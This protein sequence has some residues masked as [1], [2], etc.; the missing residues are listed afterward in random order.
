LLIHYFQYPQCTI[1]NTLIGNL[2]TVFC[3]GP[4]QTSAAK[5]IWQNNFWLI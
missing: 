2:R 1:Y 4:V 3:V 5:V